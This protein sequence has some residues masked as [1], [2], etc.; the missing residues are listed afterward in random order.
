MAAKKGGELAKFPG[1]ITAVVT[2]AGIAVIFGVAWPAELLH[3]NARWIGEGLWLGFWVLI[4]SI[5]ATA[6]MVATHDERKLKRLRQQRLWAEGKHP[7]QLRAQQESRALEEKRQADEQKR[8]AQGQAVEQRR[9]R[10]R[11]EIKGEERLREERLRGGQE[12][13]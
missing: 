8:R 4:I 12:T 13:L 1:A 2:V 3:G 7:A 11:D 5:G 10:L 6:Y 9:H